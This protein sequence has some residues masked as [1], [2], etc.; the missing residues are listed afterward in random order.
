M[1]QF[2]YKFLV[3]FL[4]G[5]IV[6]SN[7]SKGQDAGVTRLLS[8]VNL[9]CGAV[10]GTFE[11]IVN[12][13]GSSSISN[14]PVKLVSTGSFSFTLLD[15]LKKTIPSN[16]QDTLTFK[17]TFNTF[18]GGTFN[19]KIYTILAGDIKHA[20]D[21]L[22]ITIKINPMPNTPNGKSFTSCGGGLLS[23]KA[24]STSPG[25]I[26]YWYS[27][28]TS[29]IPITSGDSLTTYV[30]ST[31]TYYASSSS[32]TA[33]NSLTNTF[34]SGSG[35]KGDMFDV[36]IA[37]TLNIDSFDISTFAAV[38]DTA[39]FYYKSGTYSGFQNTASAWTFVGKIPVSTT[40]ATKVRANFGKSITLGGGKVY[41]IYITLIG[42]CSSIKGC[43]YNLAQTATTDSSN[44]LDMTIRSGDA[45]TAK[46]SG[47]SNPYRWNG[48]IYYS[49]SACTSPRV[50]VT[51]T[52]LTPVKNMAISKNKTSAGAMNSGTIAKPD[53][54]C[55]GDSLKYDLSQPS[56]YLNSDY[57]TKWKM[58]Y[59]MST[60]KG[61]STS[62]YTVTYPSSTVKGLIVFTPKTANGDSV[63]ILRGAVTN[64]ATG[65][66]S[67]FTRYIHVNQYAVSKFIASN[68][69]YGKAL[70]VINSSTPAGKINFTWTFGD[71][72]SSHAAAPAYK[73]PAPGA[74]ALKLVAYNGGC[75]DSSTITET[76]YNAPYG[77]NYVK[78]IPYHGQFNTGI[79]IDPDNVCIGDTNLYQITPPKGLTNADY[80]TK[81]KI[82]SVSLTTAFGLVT[83]DTLTTLP[84]GNKSASLSF[85]PTKYADST[86]IIR[87]NIRTIPGNCDSLMVRYVHVW[88]K[89]VANF[90]FVNA[91]AGNA[92]IF[93]DQ[94]KVA[95]S[96]VTNWIWDFGDGK[97]STAQNPSHIYAAPGLYKVTLTAGTDAG[98]GSS[99][100]LTVQQYPRATISFTTALSCNGSGSVFTDASTISPGSIKQW[101]WNFGDGNNSNVQNPSNNYIKSGPYSVKLVT[102]SDN[103]CKDSGIKKI[104]ILPKPIAVFNYK[105]ACVG[106][107]VFI[108]NNSV[109]SSNQ[110]TYAWDFGDAFTSTQSIPFHSYT[111]NGTYKISLK[112]TSKTGCS[113]TTSLYITP[114]PKPNPQVGF[115]NGCTGQNVTF[116]DTSHPGANA[117]YAWDFGDGG[118]FSAKTNTATHAYKTAKTFTFSLVLT[119]GAGC[120]D[121]LKKSISIM[122]F[123]K[124]SY[125]TADICLGN[126]ATFTNAST[127]VGPLS[128]KW[129][130]GDNSAVVT[131]T[132]AI[133]LYKAAGIY[134]VKLAAIN[135]NSCPDTFTRSIT[136]NPLPT[137]PNW[138]Y[139]QNGYRVSFTPADTTLGTYSWYF[140]TSTN[141][142]S[143]L[144]KPV[145][146]YPSL[147]G[148]YAVKLVIVSPAGCR[149]ESVDS[150]SVSKSGIASLGNSLN[151]VSVYPNPFEGKVNISY[152]IL[153]RSNVNITVSDIQGREIATLKNGTFEAGDYNDLFD[154]SKYKAAEGIYIVKI[155]AG[156]NYYISRIVNL[157]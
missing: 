3:V 111:A 4:L 137:V 130:F 7:F 148:R 145:F 60:A 144:K 140:G 34:N 23:F 138:T 152:K 38:N 146:T 78:G 53:E 29:S 30:P 64:M 150:V 128:Y 57:G 81:W 46:F 19:L 106:S 121:T 101:N 63:Y 135:P 124:A 94:S 123:P 31:T 11:V 115:V 95:V 149:A 70:A 15:T 39:Y 56:N 102:T 125:A 48:T 55:V 44:N 49:A 32:G 142:S 108:S 66:D 61:S 67:I 5:L 116:T 98:C 2:Y 104:T 132:N 69:C 6:F 26:T 109:D 96:N 100:T 129:Y 136:V 75:K 35:I 74:Y 141:D 37:R 87:T 143:N 112:I 58:S 16:N 13:F 20:N 83:K 18:N 72:D 36:S 14:I 80:G 10:N 12:N 84:S 86:F 122:D 156:D 154:A 52:V 24:P 151:G 43:A 8:P 73:Y 93:K 127:G 71:G 147:E 89:P 153:S 59:T 28:P 40:S 97:T 27:S 131:T 107:P 33:F 133:H 82:T 157:K 120:T 119:S 155:I 17:T 9:S 25:S 68:V 45:L 1:K 139:T 114:N 118:V 99:V 117:I 41:G 110:S 51:A 77:S 88:I 85:F 21:T 54:V 22:G 62:N 113:D 76:V 126:S 134:Q 92:I 47:N 79:F 65:C 90:S 50:A 91:C 105:N 103:G 42:T